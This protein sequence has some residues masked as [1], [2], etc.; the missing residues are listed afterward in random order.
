MITIRYIGRAAATHV[1]GKVTGRSYGYRRGN[2]IFKIDPRD[3]EPRFAPVDA[4][5]AD[6]EA[7]AEKE[8]AEPV[9]QDDLTKIKGITKA[10]AVSLNEL[11]I[12]TF[13]GLLDTLSAEDLAE[14]IG[15]TADQATEILIATRDKVGGK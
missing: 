13:Q 8:E 7:E 11:G 15:V 14:A 10:R 5:I 12:L 6:D 4:E 2:E 3:L 1:K 9:V